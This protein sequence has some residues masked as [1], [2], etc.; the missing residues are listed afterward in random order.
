MKPKPSKNALILLFIFCSLAN[1]AE[2]Q[3]VAPI[4]TARGQFAAGVIDNKIYIFGGQDNNGNHLYSTEM[5]DL[6]NPSAWTF[7]ADNTN[8]RIDFTSEHSGASLNGKFY[9][10][11][12]YYGEKPKSGVNA[13]EEYDPAINTWTSKKSMPT[14]RYNAVAASYNNEIFVVGGEYTQSENSTPAYYKVVEAYNPANDS[15]RKV[16]NMP[17]LRILPGIAVAGSKAYLFGGALVSDWKAYNNVYAYDFA[18]KKWTKSGLTGLPT[19]R[20]FSFGHA[21]PIL[22]GKI[23]LIG[24]ATVGKKPNLIPSTKV[25]IYDPVSN[26]W[27]AGPSLPQPA[28]WGDAVAAG[29]EIYVIGGQTG[30]GESSIVASVWKLADSWKSTLIAQETCD[31]NADGKNSSVDAGLFTNACKAGSAYWQ[32]DLNSDSQFNTKDTA[33]YKLLWKNA[34]KSCS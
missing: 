24:G 13:V 12:T 11:G 25:E 26:T 2:W 18:T 16:T 22:N 5:L 30:Q 3:A 23:Y 20:I 14:N 28:F 1:A 4:N 10:F 32:C 27:Q 15:W 31:L 19:P 6:A 8:D 21:A 29:N 34:K 9:V 7:V 33:A 17:T